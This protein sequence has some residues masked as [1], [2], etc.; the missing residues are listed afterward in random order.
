MAAKPGLYEQRRNRVYDWMAREGISM[1]VF[2][3]AEGRRDSNIRWLTGQPG[4]ALLFL[5]VGRKALLMPWDINIAKL[6]AHAEHIRPYGEFDRNPVTA[7]LKAAGIFKLPANSRIEIPSSTPY[8][9]FLKFIEALMS[10]DVICREEEGLEAVL[11]TFRMVKDDEEIRIYR[12]A[13]KITNGLIE[14]LEKQLRAG[15]IRSEYDAVRLIEEEC[16]KQGCEGTGFE[17]LAAGPGR[18]FA[19]HAFPA[20]TTEAFGSRGL[21]I[22]DFG[23][24]YR[25][26]TTDV[27]LTVASGISRSQERLLGLTE[28]AYKFAL[29]MVRPGEAALDIAAAVDSFFAKSNKTMPHALGHGIGLEAHEEPVLRSRNSSGI[30]EPGMII[31]LEPGLY[32]PR[33]GG[34]R[35]ENDILVT[36]Q[37]P[38][39]LTSSKIIRL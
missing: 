27:T 19:I 16:R 10:F 18:S 38:E 34:C 12:R 24:K 1:A 20:Y 8:P 32:D 11:K 13:A 35:L 26:Y 2:E 15:K 39:V 22:L 30:L 33:L 21:S 23:V 37:G 6:H 5:T 3:D 7:C 31:T 4:D 28:R 25:G 9:R 29:D 36:A 14:I 17:T